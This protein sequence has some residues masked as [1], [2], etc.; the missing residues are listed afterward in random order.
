MLVRPSKQYEEQVMS[1]KEEMSQNGDSFDGCAGL[2]EVR[3]FDE[4]IDFERRL[5]VKYKEGYVPSEV[6][7]AVRQNDD[8]VVGIIDFRHPLS[9]FLKNFGGNIGYSI[10][11]SERRKGYASEM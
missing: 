11:P 7:L 5:R 10:R 3:T 2:E 8:R 6:F 4:W 1:Y 9:D